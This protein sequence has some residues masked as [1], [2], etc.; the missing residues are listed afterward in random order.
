M[1]IISKSPRETLL[2]GKRIAKAAGPGSILC[3]CGRLGSGKTV[4]AKGIAW[5]LGIN[6]KNIVSPTFVLIRQYNKAKLPLYHFDLYRLK[7]AQEIL[8]LG[9]EEYF[10]ARGISIVEWAERLKELK[11]S[12]CLNIDISFKGRRIRAIHLKPE[13]EYYKRMAKRIYEDTRG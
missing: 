6:P 11:P 2:I 13:G 4:L 8:D 10:Y 1:K 9:Y 5:G 3:L 12:E 7:S